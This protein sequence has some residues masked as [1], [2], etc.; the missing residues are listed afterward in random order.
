MDWNENLL[1]NLKINPTLR[2]IINKVSGY[3]N[4]HYKPFALK[5]FFFWMNRNAMENMFAALV[6]RCSCRLTRDENVSWDHSKW[7]RYKTWT[8]LG[9]IIIPNIILSPGHSS[10]S[11]ADLGKKLNWARYSP[12][13]R[14]RTSA[15]R[16][17]GGDA[18]PSQ[19]SSNSLC[20]LLFMFALA[21]NLCSFWKSFALLASFFWMFFV[22]AT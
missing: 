14:V 15:T 7:D 10:L 13:L 21:L 8:V 3:Q 20:Y 16:K 2:M 11:W 17:L 19:F 4:F 18:G 9:I 22:S 5:W 6:S 1:I 12:L